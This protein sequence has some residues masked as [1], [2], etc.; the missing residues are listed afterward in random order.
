MAVISTPPIPSKVTTVFAAWAFAPTLKRNSKSF[1]SIAVLRQSI[2]DESSSSSWSEL[3]FISSRW[4]SAWAEESEWRIQRWSP[5]P[6][7]CWEHACRVEFTTV[8]WVNCE[9]HLTARDQCEKGRDAQW[10]T[11]VSCS[12]LPAHFLAYPLRLGRRNTIG[13]W[14]RPRILMYL[15][16]ISRMKLSYCGRLD[17][18]IRGQTFTV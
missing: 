14:S 8:R 15:P 5:N 10:G 1:T 3:S 16:D 7:Q 11:L 17:A 6:Q 12:R 2:C 9:N 18:H 4:N 13:W